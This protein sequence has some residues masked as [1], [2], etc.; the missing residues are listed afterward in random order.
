MLVASCA[1]WY[2]WN[3]FQIEDY[4][5]LAATNTNS[6]TH[7]LNFRMGFFTKGSFKKKAPPIRKS[8]SLN[9]LS[10]N[11][12]ERAADLHPDPNN[13]SDYSKILTSDQDL[14]HRLISFLF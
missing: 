10:S 11:P 13:A 12:T 7:L 4:T 3:S 1:P 6:Y 9:N 5:F 14:V 2:N 8:V